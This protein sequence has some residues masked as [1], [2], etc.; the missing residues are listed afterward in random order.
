LLIIGLTGIVA[1]YVLCSSAFFQA[2]YKIDQQS[3]EKIA[4]QLPKDKFNEEQVQQIT[5]GLTPL[6]GKQFAGELDFFSNVEQST[7]TY[8]KDV[9]DIVLKNSIT[10]NAL[11]VLIGILI[12]I[13][14]FAISLGP[15]T[16]A[17]LSEIF[18]NRIRGLAISVAGTFN[19]LVSTLVVTLFPMELAKFGSGVTFALF[20]VIACLALL[21][22][23]KY[24]PETKGKSL[25]ELE[26][27]LSK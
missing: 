5:T 16:W 22:V 24:V 11:L 8:Y 14:A 9:K 6:V 26:K 2:E 20:A 13:G 1:A 18:P 3:I 23:L 19:A 4:L 17:L 25:E 7:G 15:V 10:M 21:F 27:M 12:F